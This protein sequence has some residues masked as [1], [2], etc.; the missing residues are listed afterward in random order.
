M[1]DVTNELMKRI[2]A[3]MSGLKRGQCEL[4]AEINATRGTMVSIQQDLHN[5]HTTLARHDA[6]LDRIESRLE[7]RELQEAQAKFEHCP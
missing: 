2:Q 5:I 7:L 3:D 6:R 4:K 1:A